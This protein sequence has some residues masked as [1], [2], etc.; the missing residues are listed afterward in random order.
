MNR[1]PSH[2]DHIP[3]IIES[4]SRQDRMLFR[5][6]S[7]YHASALRTTRPDDEVC[8]LFRR[9]PLY[10]VRPIRHKSLQIHRRLLCSR[11]DGGR[12]GWHLG[13]W[14]LGGR[15]H[16]FTVTGTWMVHSYWRF[17]CNLWNP[18]NE[19]SD[20]DTQCR[21]KTLLTYSLRPK[22]IRVSLLVVWM[23]S[24]ICSE[25]GRIICTHF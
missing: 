11:L 4:A 10:L 5:T 16:S 19:N 20:I 13:I 8:L 18:T 14:R 9:K 24:W 1:G 12:A 23:L 3:G 7:R 2:P 6:H 22:E 25:A 15:V 21:K 17:W